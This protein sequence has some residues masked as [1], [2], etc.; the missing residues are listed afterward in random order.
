MSLETFTRQYWLASSYLEGR[1][2][3]AAMTR[4]S[5]EECLRN[6]ALR[7][8]WRRLRRAARDT[9]NAHGVTPRGAARAESLL[10]CDTEP[11]AAP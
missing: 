4:S 6:L 2:V 5:A 1:G 8:R 9:A 10:P 7:C 3:P 11:E